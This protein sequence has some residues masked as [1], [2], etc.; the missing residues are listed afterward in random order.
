MRDASST[1]DDSKAA[2]ASSL[3]LRL[4]VFLILLWILPF[5]LLAP[6]LAHVLSGGSG[7]P[8]VAT[9]TTTVVVVQTILG[10]VGMF[11]AGAEVKTIVKGSTRRHAIAAIW[12]IFI[13]GEIRGDGPVGTEPNEAP[14]PKED[15]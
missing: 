10:L 12:S 6:E 3:R 15:A 9:V 13:H 2:G 8:S 5:W 7:N 14:S 4:G 11:V 1:T